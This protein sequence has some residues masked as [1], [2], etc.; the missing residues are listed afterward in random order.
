MNVPA[1][2]R[3]KQDLRGT[4]LVVDDE[5][6]NRLYLEQLLSSQGVT[7]RTAENGAAALAMVQIRRP[8]LVLTDVAMPDMDGFEL[9]RAIK[10]LASTCDV[11]VI[12]VTARRHIDDLQKGFDLGAMDYIRRPFDARELLL[13]VGNALALKRSRD[14]LARWKRRMSHELE[15]AG[16]IQQ[17]IFSD[18]PCFSR[19]FEIRV[20]YKASMDIGGDAFDVVELPDGRC[21]VYLAD[22]SGHGVGPAMIASMLKVAAAES[23]RAYFSQGP[24]FICNELHMRIRRTL[25]NPWYYATLFMAIYEPEGGRWVCMNCGH[26]DPI[27]MRDGAPVPYPCGG[28]GVPVGMALGPER[29]YAEADQTVLEHCAGL[30]ILLYTDGLSEAVH[31]E[32]GEECGE[33]NLRRFFAQVVSHPEEA[34][35]PEVLLDLLNESYVAG[36]DDCTSIVIRMNDP[37]SVLLD[38]EVPLESGVISDVCEQMEQLVLARVDEDVAARVRLVAMEYAMNVVDHSGLDADSFMCMQLLLEGDSVRLQFSDNGMGWDYNT[39]ASGML[40][41]DDYAE[42]GRGLAIA[43]GAAD[44]S[45]RYRRDLRNVVCYHF[46]KQASE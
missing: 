32:T 4:V 7:V 33:E 34:R 42:G 24:A 5:L 43:H 26:P 31:R 14:A 44:R 10:E 18:T 2:N 15:L 39:A 23:I 19:D 28:G 8:D 30:Q 6:P 3:F 41:V 46:R 16:V 20:S 35:V 45:E 13:R 21:C 40:E 11:P 1:A 12:M 29:P 25:N 37:S 27:L 17:S 9:C 22:V 36:S 38:T